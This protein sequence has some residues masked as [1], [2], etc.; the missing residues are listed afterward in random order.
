MSGYAA[1]RKSGSR[2]RKAQLL[3]SFSFFPEYPTLRGLAPAPQSHLR[4]RRGRRA[5][6]GLT[7]ALA[8]ECGVAYGASRGIRKRRKRRLQSFPLTPYQQKG[9]TAIVQMLAQIRDQNSH[10]PH[11][12]RL[13]QFGDS[14][15]HVVDEAIAG[16]NL[17]HL[18]AVG[19]T[20]AQPM[21]QETEHSWNKG[22]D[23]GM[24][25]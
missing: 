12:D 24:E 11:T 2:R 13:K 23:Y 20:V 18:E 25:I 14:V 8:A 16:R 5:A 15:N 9:L 17:S 3:Q 19:R 10:L 21:K 1:N 22:D 6:Y 4:R 7:P